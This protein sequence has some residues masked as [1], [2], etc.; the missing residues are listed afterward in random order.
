LALGTVKAKI[1]KLQLEAKRAEDRA[2]AKLERAGRLLSTKPGDGRTQTTQNTVNPVIGGT[3]TAQSTGNT[4]NP[5]VQ[6][7]PVPPVAV[8]NP[9]STYTVPAVPSGVVLPTIQPV[10]SISLAVK[11][12]GAEEN[13]EEAPRWLRHDGGQ[14]VNTIEMAIRGVQSKETFS[15]ITIVLLSYLKYLGGDLP[16]SQY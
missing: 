15:P 8:Q 14:L 16:L 12:G 10:P 13:G 9:P 6:N 3:Q 4:Q 5:G 7:P 2:I 11:R 1:P